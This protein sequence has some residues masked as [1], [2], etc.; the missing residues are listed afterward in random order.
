MRVAEAL[1]WRSGDNV[2][3]TAPECPSNVPP[4]SI[5][6]SSVWRYASFPREGRILAEDIAA[7]MDAR[8]RLLSLSFVESDTGFRNDLPAMAHLAHL[9]HN[10]GALSC[11]DGIQGLGALQL[12]VRACDID[13]LGAGS[14][15]WL[16]GP[17]HVGLLYV[18]LELL[19][20]P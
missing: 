4:G 16:L 3:I 17:S 13:F 8:T 6:A 7:R 1:H 10:R 18:R 11:M 2:V 20:E 19:A 5:C 9:A 15:K 12:D 14:P